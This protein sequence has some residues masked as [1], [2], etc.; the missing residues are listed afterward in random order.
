M[1]SKKE[2]IVNRKSLLGILVAFFISVLTLFIFQN[3]GTFSYNSDTSKYPKRGSDG[4]ILMTIYVEPT[5]KVTSIYYESIIGTRIS[6]YDL[7]KTNIDYQIKDLN[8][9]GKF[10]NYNNKFPYYIQATFK[11]IKYA[12]FA[13]AILYLVLM[14]LTKI[15]FKIE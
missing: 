7:R 8:Y 2:I 11:D 10:H 5:D 6:N 4:K 3:F 9:G 12:L 13:W 1:S 14:V 15:K